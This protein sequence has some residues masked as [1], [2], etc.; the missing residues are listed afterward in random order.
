MEELGVDYKLKPID[1]VKLQ[2]KEAW[3][4]AI[5][6][7]GTTPVLVDNHNKSKV[8]ESGA[9][10]IYLADLMGRYLPKY[11]NQNARSEV[12]QWVFFATSALGPI[13]KQVLFY[14]QND[15]QNTFPID[16]GQQEIRR[17]FSA[18]NNHFQSHV[19]LASW[20]VSIADYAVLPWVLEGSESTAVKLEND[21]PNLKRW[22]A[23]MK[24]RPG[25]KRGLKI[26]KREA[27]G[28]EEPKNCKLCAM[29]SKL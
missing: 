26:A 12:T 4:L 18:L 2:H 29:G 15:P 23:I 17:L 11:S 5:N 10:L 14:L 3:F 24:S 20:G 8:F 1:L 28:P 13:I 21:F 25:V 6:P 27:T 16:V 7:T 9:I 19:F 22:V